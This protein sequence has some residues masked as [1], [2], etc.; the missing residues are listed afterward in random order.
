M[1]RRKGRPRLGRYEQTAAPPIAEVADVVEEGVLIAAAAV[2]MAVKNQAIVR[3]LR[4]R[5]AFEADWYAQTV[6]D[7]L[8]TMAR[9]KTADAER[10]D[11][12][13][14]RASTKTGQA[15]SHGD[16]RLRD[17]PTLRRRREVLS[18][19]ITRL[20]ELACDD[21]FVDGVVERSRSEVSDDIAE[22][23]SGAALRISPRSAELSADERDIQLADLRE[24]IAQLGAPASTANSP[25]AD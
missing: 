10:V 12:E 1:A 20:I 13:I 11:A 25:E 7:G 15:D 3:T 14:T 2:R 5:A 21:E 6:R 8:T 18:L 16:Y 19:L 24:A 17:L 9:E 23:V 4:D 22:A